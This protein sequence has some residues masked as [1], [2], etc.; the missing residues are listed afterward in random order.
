EMILA[1]TDDALAQPQPGPETVHDFV[2]SPNVDTTSSAFDTE[3]APNTEGTP[4]T[5]VDLLNVCMKDEMRRN[6]RML[7][8]GEDV[9][10]A[11][12]EA[13]LPRVKG[14][15]G[16]FKVTWALRREFGASRVY[17]TR[18]AEANI[19]ARAIGLALRGFKPVV[20]VQFF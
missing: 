7:L 3:D 10:D 9:A 16:V 18:L 13:S 4:T 19:V 6:P 15:G 12:R 1:A 17:N 14:K 11:S 8:F 5:M 20:E 2:Y